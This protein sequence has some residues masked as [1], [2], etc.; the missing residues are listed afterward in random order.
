MPGVRFLL[1]IVTRTSTRS[2]TCFCS[3]ADMFGV[4]ACW[5]SKLPRRRMLPD[6]RDDSARHDRLRDLGFDSGA[7][8]CAVRTGWDTVPRYSS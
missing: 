4:R 1:K 5:L 6:W 7:H 3:S 8:R 2:S